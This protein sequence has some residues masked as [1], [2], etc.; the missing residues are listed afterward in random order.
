MRPLTSGE[1]HKTLHIDEKVSG[2]KFLVDTGAAISI[3]PFRSAAP[4]RPHNV[5]SASGHRLRAW[6]TVQK[7]VV[8]NEKIFKWNFLLADVTTPILGADFLDNFNCKIDFEKRS[9][10]FPDEPY[11]HS[12]LQKSK[13]TQHTPVNFLQILDEFPEITSSTLTTATPKHTIRHT[14]EVNCSPIA[15][16][17]RRLDPEK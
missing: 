10:S 17:P 16:K 8:F 15:Q 12:T 4:Q 2:L 6:G 1:N 7:E 9:L 14:I 13:S 5:I 11:V 3:F